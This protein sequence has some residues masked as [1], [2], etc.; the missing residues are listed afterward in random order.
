M[1]TLLHH[2]AFCHADFL[3]SPLGEWTRRTDL[4]RLTPGGRHIRAK[5]GLTPAT[6]NVYAEVHGLGEGSWS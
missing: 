6:A 2:R 5:K 3:N 1:H 4:K